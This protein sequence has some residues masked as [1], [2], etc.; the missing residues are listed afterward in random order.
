MLSIKY[1]IPEGAFVAID[2]R[3]F[4]FWYFSEVIK[5]IVDTLKQ[6]SSSKFFPSFSPFRIFHCET[7][8]F[9]FNSSSFSLGSIISSFIFLCYVR[10]FFY[11][12]FT[13]SFLLNLEQS[14]CHLLSYIRCPP[15]K[16]LSS[17]KLDIFLVN[18]F[19]S[20]FSPWGL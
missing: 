6:A 2:R 17:N 8:D 20:C 1:I 11:L 7:V 19:L 13:G 18:S 15:S 3:L 4:N 16:A 5:G 10:I 14:P 9:L 12:N